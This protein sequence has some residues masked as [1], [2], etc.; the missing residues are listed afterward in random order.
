MYYLKD[1]KGIGN[2][3]GSKARID[4]EE[5]MEN[6]KLEKLDFSLGG[7]KKYMLGFLKRMKEIKR[8]KSNDILVIQ[9]P[10]HLKYNKYFYKLL[11]K[12]QKKNIKII[13]IIHDVL[14]LR[15][16][17]KNLDNYDE[18]KLLNRFDILISHNKKMTNWL[19]KEGV[20]TKIVELE[21]FDYLSEC[22]RTDTDGDFKNIYF[23]GNLDKKKSGFL[24]SKELCKIKSN[25]I[26]F[27]PNY[28]LEDNL[29]KFEYRGIFKPEELPNEFENGFGLIWDG[30]R[31]DECT[32][33]TGN[34]LKYNNPH[35]TSLYLSSGLP[36]IIW[37][38]A[39]LSEFIL[40]NKLGFVI[41]SLNEVDEILKNMSLDEYRKL[42]K[43]VEKTKEKLQD[44][45]FVKRALDKSKKLLE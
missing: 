38:K 39:A 25:I 2:D 42:K 30:N 22:K 44:G 20:T 5:I 43:N 10:Y 14:L 18:I 13:A 15:G 7:C 21:L 8:L 31:I 27:G 6:N 37:S 12:I 3:A 11:F 36:V 35:K 33:E 1:Y 9:Y 23:A 24:Y 17:E 28:K 45:Y 4:I 34:Y 19:I 29:G 32:G 41:D 16:M 40:N 26:L